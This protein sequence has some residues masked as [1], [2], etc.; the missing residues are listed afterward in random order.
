MSTVGPDRRRVALVRSGGRVRSGYLVRADLVLTA[1]HG[2]TTGDTVEV[3]VGPGELSEARLSGTCAESVFDDRVDIAVIRTEHPLPGQA[4]SERFGRV[5]DHAALLTAQ[6]VGYPRSGLRKNTG[7]PFRDTTHLW[8]E[9]ASLSGSRSGTL[10]LRVPEPPTPVPTADEEDGERQ[11]TQPDPSP[12]AGMSGA[13]VWVRDRIVG[14]AGQHDGPTWLRVGRL[15]ALWDQDRYTPIRVLLSLPERA[16]DLVDVVPPTVAE[17]TTTAYQALVRSI[18]PNALLGRSEELAAINRFCSGGEPYQ[19]LQAGPWAG[20]SALTSWWALHPPDGVDVVSF[21]VSRRKTGQADSTAFLEA[22]TEQ[23]AAVL[24]QDYNTPSPNRLLAE[25]RRLIELA[26]NSERRSVLVVDG[27]DEDTSAERQ[28]PSIVSLLPERLGR[29]LKVLV[30]SRPRP[31]LPTDVDPAHPVRRQTPVPLAPSDYAAGLKQRAGHELTESFRVADERV[32]I[33]GLM[34]ASGGGLTKADLVELTWC[35]PPAI[36]ALLDSSFGRILDTRLGPAGDPP[37][38]VFAHEELRAQAA[39]Q[40]HPDT[41]HLD[42]INQWA[43][44]YRDQHW[45]DTTPEYLL[46]PYAEMLNERAHDDKDPDS[47]RRLTGLALDWDRQQRIQLVDHTWRHTIDEMNDALGQQ[48]RADNPDLQACVRLAI[49]RNDLAQRIGQVPVDLLMLWAMLGEIDHAESLAIAITDDEGRTQALTDLAASLTPSEA[50]RVQTIA[51]HAEQAANTIA[52]EWLRTRAV[53]RLVAAIAASVPNR[54]RSLACR[55]EQ[56]AVNL[57]SDALTARAL[58][59]LAAAVAQIDPRR[60]E[61][62]ANHAE[63]IAKSTDY[64]EAEQMTGALTRLIATLAV[65][66]PNRAQRL[67]NFAEHTAM[68]ITRDENRAR[69]L[70]GLV[71]AL[72]LIDPHRAQTLAS[73]VEHATSAIRD[74]SAEA[75]VL[76]TLIRAV[77]AADPDRAR[78]IADRGEHAMAR[79]SDG[80]FRAEALTTLAE[81]LAP[82]DP[83]RARVLAEQAERAATANY[84]PSHDLIQAAALARL[85]A[86]LTSIDPERALTLAD[87]AEQAAN[88]IR[89]DVLRDRA[90]SN[91]V[92]TL[93]SIDSLRAERTAKTITDGGIRTHALATLV[94]ALTLI[95]PPRATILADHAEQAALAINHD[96][97]RARALTS[98]AKAL[99]STDAARARSLADRAERTATDG[100]RHNSYE[101]RAVALTRLAAALASIDP[102]RALTLADHAEQ[103]ANA[104]TGDAAR[105]EGLAALAAVLDSL[106]TTRARSL[107]DQA[108]QA[109]ST[110]TEAFARVRVLTKVIAALGSIEPHRVEI[111]ADRAEQTASTINFW[112]RSTVLSELVVALAPN[113]LNRARRLADQTKQEAIHIVDEDKD[114]ALLDI[115]AALAPIETDRAEKTASA[116]TDD[117]YRARAQTH[118]VAALARTE[119]QRA[120]RIAAGI[121]HPGSRAE[122]LVKLLAAVHPTDPGRA[123]SLADQVEQAATNLADN[124]ERAE[125]LTNLAATLDPTDPDRARSLADRAAQAAITIT[126][127][128]D[129][130]QAVARVGIAVARS[131]LPRARRLAAQALALADEQECLDL[132]RIVDP[133]ALVIAAEE[134]TGRSYVTEPARATE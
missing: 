64:G 92:A 126:N 68:A 54:A 15:D 104:I 125:A 17:R 112:D 65:I 111:L 74:P 110:I 29:N 67:G 49:R 33:I 3:T 28:L 102:E 59:E 27:L 99:A 76:T 35:R 12:W 19:W 31:G 50:D 30:T 100:D 72:V 36:Q 22:V 25:Y 70:T 9:I 21:F 2:L 69:A 37:T 46:R 122:A 86:A 10:Q 81:T 61:S 96:A 1:A 43:D 116:I 20:K 39:E 113:D 4:D 124:R 58:T 79:I 60:A 131:S 40:L 38:Y 48:T 42:Q 85:V 84:P 108:D 95:D 11:G 34:S 26:G 130:A 106:D 121:T 45:P 24:G 52:W 109:T 82:I 132:L 91:F 13:S 14:V 117:W 32:D 133:Q 51:D 101:V 120:E 23:L 93:A 41:S 77:R 75:S 114:P 97:S 83:Q 94:A 107:A 118:I 18:A 115:V 80:I 123:R 87:H 47:R 90:L 129:R 62:L 134:R 105:A 128:C 16:V 6:A 7:G 53:V 88:A 8:G 73:R 44:H 63:Q 55:A 98:L 89:S 78:A 57:T 5:G 119:P 103:A 56:M 127:D 71:E 66:D